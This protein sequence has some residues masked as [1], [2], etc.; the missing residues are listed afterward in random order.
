[1]ERNHIAQQTSSTLPLHSELD[2][3]APRPRPLSVVRFR[4]VLQ[5]M[6]EGPGWSVV[7][8]SVDFALLCAAVTL[9]LGAG[10]VGRPSGGRAALLALPVLV[11]LLLGARGLYRNRLRAPLLDGISPVVSCVSV[12]ATGVAALGLLL[13][14]PPSQ[15]DLV[16]TWLFALLAL[17]SGRA[18]LS[19]VKGRARTGRRVGKPVLVVGAGVVGV[20]IAHRLENHP[21]YG[22][23]PVGFLDDDPL[24]GAAAGGRDLPVLGPLENLDAV[25]RNTS[26]RHIIVAF[27]SIADA[28]LS[29]LVQH[30]H[31]KGITVS[32]VPRMFDTINDRAEYGSVGGLPLMTFN[33]VDPRGSLFALK[34]AADRA[35][36]LVMLVVL[37]PL[38]VAVAIG[39]RL[40]SPGP[41]LFRQRR[42]GRDGQTLR[43]AQ[44][45]L[46]A[47]VRG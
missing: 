15:S 7:R 9:S 18:A 39:V 14:H 37:S 10:A 47:P 36:A 33:G 43:S 42:V 44:V 31:E 13:G 38:M 45:P 4:G 8:P 40:S 34:H 25:L 32:V 6:L 5:W 22:L 2:H 21:E 46:D 26:A 17:G 35:M 16:R 19:A 27:S 29:R 28:R 12:G 23:A 3:S 11:M 1:M 30:C 41:A 24:S 20:Q